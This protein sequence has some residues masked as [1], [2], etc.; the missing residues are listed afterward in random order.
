MKKKD[1][2]DKLFDLK[3]DL[4]Q[5]YINDCT[6]L[7]FVAK[8]APLF[9]LKLL[10]DH[11]YNLELN[12]VDSNGRSAL[13]YAVME[14]HV[15]NVKL[16]TEANADVHLGDTTGATPLQTA[17]RIKDLPHTGKDLRTRLGRIIKYLNNVKPQPTNQW[18]RTIF[19]QRG[20]TTLLSYEK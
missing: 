7:M 18:F 12:A 13:H 5:R 17:K 8:R 15:E 11:R 1:N 10:L 4:N 20:K 9:P 2:F 14:G 3:I 6:L 16:L 19:K